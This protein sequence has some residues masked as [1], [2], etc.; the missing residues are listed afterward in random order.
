MAL[1]ALAQFASTF[2]TKNI[3]MKIEYKFNSEIN[4]TLIDESNKF[5]IQKHKLNKL[6]ENGRNSFTFDI[7]GEGCA[8]VQV[9][10]KS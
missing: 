8:L 9:K 2:Y 5:L 4:T 3:N 10:D 6:K 7:E 1:D